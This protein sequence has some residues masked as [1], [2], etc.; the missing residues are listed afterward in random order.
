L[1]A[2][3][4][5]FYGRHFFQTIPLGLSF[6]T[7]TQLTAQFGHRH[8]EPRGHP[9]YRGFH[10]P[11]PLVGGGVV[12]VILIGAL[13]LSASYVVGIVMVTNA[14][15]DRRTLARAYATAVLVYVP[16]PLLGQLLIL[17]AVAYLGLFG[18]AVPA[19]LVER[20]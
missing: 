9:P 16:V 8:T 3:T 10:N 11:T 2:E 6:A 15:P 4:I 5:A 14:K 13:L 12:T 7:V 18:W 1:V 20:R 19:I 17:P